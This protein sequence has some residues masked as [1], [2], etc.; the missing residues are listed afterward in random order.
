MLLC[1]P[2]VSLGCSAGCDADFV[3]G[4]CGCGIHESVP[5]VGH[6]DCIMLYIRTERSKGTALLAGTDSLLYRD[7]R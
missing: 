6:I 2:W 5:G 1:A 7:L 3:I 4:K